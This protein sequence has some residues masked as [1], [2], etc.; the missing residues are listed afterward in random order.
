MSKNGKKITIESLFLTAEE[1]EQNFRLD[2]LEDGVYDITDIPRL[3]IDKSTRMSLDAEEIAQIQKFLDT[4]GSD[5]V[6]IG[7]AYGTD[8][9][10]LLAKQPTEV[11]SWSGGFNYGTSAIVTNCPR[12]IMILA[13]N[14]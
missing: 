13:E 2:T 12:E 3:C 11:E 9:T 1:M 5:N 8:A 14:D 10:I 4:H 7:A 6:A